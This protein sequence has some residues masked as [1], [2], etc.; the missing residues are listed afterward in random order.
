LLKLLLSNDFA[1]H[2][3]VILLVL[4]Y[5]QQ[6]HLGEG[7][8]NG[9]KPVSSRM[10][11]APRKKTNPACKVSLLPL[12]VAAPPQRK[13]KP[14]RLKPAPNAAKQKA[15]KP[16]AKRCGHVRGLRTARRIARL[17][18]CLQEVKFSSPTEPSAGETDTPGA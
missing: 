12:S 17:Q 10:A 3:F 18:R 15:R 9:W 6:N 1:I 5:F 16:A 7:I 11:S 14:Q 8:S 13:V 4:E 2:D